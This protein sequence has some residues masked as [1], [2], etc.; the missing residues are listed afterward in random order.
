MNKISTIFTEEI[1]CPY[2]GHEFGDSWECE[3]R[4]DNMCCD[5]CGKEFTYERCVEVTY[6]SY[7]ND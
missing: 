4:D 5:N 6:C 2:C 3:D 1:V 7:K